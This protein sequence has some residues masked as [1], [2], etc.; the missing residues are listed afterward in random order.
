METDWEVEIGGGAAV[1]EALWPGFVDLRRSPERLGEIAEAAAFPA[2]ADLLLA[3]NGPASP[4]WTAKCDLWKPDPVELAIPEITSPAAVSDA[5]VQPT[6]LACYVDLLLVEGRVFAQ[7]TEAEG[8]CRK[9]VARLESLPLPNCRVDLI[10]RQAIAG[11]DEG[12]GVTAYLSGTG[13][14]QSAAAEALSAALAAFA[15]SIPAS[16]APATAAT[17]LQ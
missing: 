4:L 9:W 6:A 5:G 10:V 13:K 17:K 7:W 8:F 11:E 16:I 14:D 2:L 3:L 12:F 15:D 1:I